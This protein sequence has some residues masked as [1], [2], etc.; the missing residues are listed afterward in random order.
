MTMDAPVICEQYL[1][2]AKLYHFYLNEPVFFDHI[3]YITMDAP[4][5]CEQL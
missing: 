2:R 5:I 3:K 1:A 4:V